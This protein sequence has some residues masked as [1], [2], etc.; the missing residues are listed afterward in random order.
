M[1]TE[2]ET[3]AAVSYAQGAGGARSLFRSANE[4]AANSV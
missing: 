1:Q 3:R 2:E 4:V